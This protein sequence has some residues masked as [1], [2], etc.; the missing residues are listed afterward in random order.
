[1]LKVTI[2]LML[3]LVGVNAEEN[4]EGHDHGREAETKKA[5]VFKIGKDI[6]QMELSA[7]RKTGNIIFTFKTGEKELVLGKAP[8]MK[9]TL[10]DKKVDLKTIPVNSKEKASVFSIKSSDIGPA[11]AIDLIVNINGKDYTLNLHQ[12]H[13]GHDHGGHGHSHE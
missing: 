2:A 1:M 9:V 11:I 12:Q 8:T 13:K 10:Q 3:F 5:K 4:H 7:D 6:G